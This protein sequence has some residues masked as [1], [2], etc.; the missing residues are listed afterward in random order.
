MV[1]GEKERGCGYC[2]AG[3]LDCRP[4]GLD[5]GEH[6]AE[7]WPCSLAYVLNK[8]HSGFIP[9][10]LVVGIGMRRMR[11]GVVVTQNIPHTIAAA[12]ERVV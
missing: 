1:R 6:V 5:L 9:Q 2:S 8:L 4:P 7:R 12:N 10:M 3:L 11:M